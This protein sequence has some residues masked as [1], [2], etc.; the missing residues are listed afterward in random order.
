M[1]ISF[2]IRWTHNN[3]GEYT[4]TQQVEN[5]PDTEVMKKGKT[6]W[7]LTAKKKINILM[8]PCLFIKGKTKWTIIF[9][10]MLE[11]FGNVWVWSNRNQWIQL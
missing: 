2:T 6:P 11:V 5:E 4:Q 9:S 10:G 8:L 7:S 3:L 1:C